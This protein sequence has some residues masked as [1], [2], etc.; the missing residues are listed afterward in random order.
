MAIDTK[1]LIKYIKQLVEAETKKAVAAEVKKVLLEQRNH[2]PIPKK[3]PIQ[4]KKPIKFT[5]NPILNEMLNE[6][7]Q[8]GKWK[9][10]SNDPSAPPSAY[11]NNMNMNMASNDFVD[12]D[13]QFNDMEMHDEELTN[14]YMPDMESVIP[15][16]QIKNNTSVQN[17]QNLTGIPNFLKSQM[18]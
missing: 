16:K 9:T 6:T 18:K 17:Q 1:K 4:E 14:S 11:L 12:D 7:A 2:Q 5:A 3:Q 8:D 13:P 15:I 10:L